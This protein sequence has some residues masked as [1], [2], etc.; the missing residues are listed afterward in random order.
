M[1]HEN[2]YGLKVKKASN[3][4]ILRYLIVEDGIPVPEVCLW[5]D[6]VSINSY[7][8][9]ERYAYALLRYLRYLKRINI[10]YKDVTKQRV[11]EEYVK[12]LLGLN[13]KILNV[14]TNMT[15][16]A[17]KMNVSVL[18]SFYYWLEDNMKVMHN[19]ITYESKDI[20]NIK[21]KEIKFL[22][23]QIW[24]F[25]VEQ[26]ILSRLT[27]KQKRNHLKWY[28]E[29]EKENISKFLPTLRDKLIFQI[30]VETGMRIGE[31]LGL[32]L[33]DFDPHNNWLSVIKRDNIKNQAKAKTKERDVP[34]YETLSEQIQI[35][36]ENERRK[37]DIYYSEYLFLNHKGKY[38]GEPLKAR[39]FL[40]ILKS[41]AEKSG[42]KRSEIR[43]HSG[44]STR[45]Q[46]LVEI[47]REHPELGVTEGLILEEL[48]WS[49]VRSLKVYE[50]GYT[51]KQRKK[52][53]DKIRTIVIK[54]S[55]E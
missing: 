2:T 45:A 13:E 53:M 38:K 34:I 5:L 35:Y 39:N 47:M 7:L 48:G 8:T 43:T 21:F 42:M 24:E 6:F 46:E 14:D 10:H 44:R 51:K 54:Q 16:T 33:G 23:G 19:P 28:S 41:A 17:V 3:G 50:K 4:Q 29:E 22:Y 31:I 55:D 1:K 30:S 18:K 49:S 20:K 32:R 27:Y 9:G 26:T 52:V 11:I 12:Q 36:K 37:S 25:N 40:H 15:Y